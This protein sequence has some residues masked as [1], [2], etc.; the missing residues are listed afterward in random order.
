MLR[1]RKLIALL[2]DAPRREQLATNALR[3]AERFGW[4]RVAE[5]T[6]EVYAKA[7]E[8]HRRS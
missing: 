5:T 7:I 4:P 3:H 2:G 6:R 8:W 1:A